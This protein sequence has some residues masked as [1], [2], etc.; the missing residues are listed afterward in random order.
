MSYKEDKDN[1]YND[2]SNSPVLQREKSNNDVKSLAKLLI[3]D[4]EP[5]IVEVLKLG[6]TK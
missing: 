2:L 6:L 5:D 4:D 3:V 1:D